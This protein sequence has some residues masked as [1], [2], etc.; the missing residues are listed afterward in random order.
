[1]PKE[2]LQAG[3]RLVVHLD[4]IEI[5]VPP[6]GLDNA[7]SLKE[8]LWLRR[9][10]EILQALSVALLISPSKPSSTKQNGTDQAEEDR[11]LVQPTTPS[12]PL[13]KIVA[14]PQRT[15]EVITNVQQ[16]LLDNERPRLLYGYLLEALLSCSGSAF[17]FVADVKIDGANHPI[18]T[19]RAC[20]NLDQN[21]QVNRLYEVAVEPVNAAN[22][23]LPFF[24]AALKT[25]LPVISN[26]PTNDPRSYGVPED[27]IPLQAYLGIPLFKAS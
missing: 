6:G 8:W 27:H 14:D 17:G 19:A 1:M 26:D 2:N 10:E 4:R 9:K 22:N 3:D 7:T 20:T 5:K 24:Q 11:H 12:T 18:A 25:G 15:L 16:R 21:N 13:P 23:L